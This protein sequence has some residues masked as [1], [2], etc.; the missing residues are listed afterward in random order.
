VRG[1]PKGKK[2]P[3]SVSR[4][5]ALTILLDRADAMRGAPFFVLRTASTSQ[6]ALRTIPPNFI[7]LKVSPDGKN[8]IKIHLRESGWCTLTGRKLEAASK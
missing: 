7:V 6:A 5:Q 8:R 3:R 2:K 1:W 4:K